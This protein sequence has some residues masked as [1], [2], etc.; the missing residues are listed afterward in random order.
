[1]P[2]DLAV[3]KYPG[4]VTSPTFSFLRP[5]SPHFQSDGF[6]YTDLRTKKALAHPTP[7]TAI[8][9][10]LISGRRTKKAWMDLAHNRCKDLRKNTLMVSI[11]ISTS[12]GQLFPLVYASPVFRI[13]VTL[14][15]VKTALSLAHAFRSS[16]SC[17]TSDTSRANASSHNT[18]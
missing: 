2:P 14:P 8:G 9:R 3:G 12:L 13:G 7:A 1:M 16:H 4:V 15:P 5:S 18:R 11:R 6:A 10:F 17:L